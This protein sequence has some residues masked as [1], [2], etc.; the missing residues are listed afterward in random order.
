MKWKE[1]SIRLWTDLSSLGSL[2]FFLFTTL[3]FFSIQQY[4]VV[5]R[6]LGFLII[7]TLLTASLRLIY[8]KDRPRKRTH[9]TLLD[10]IDAGSFPSLHAARIFF[11]ATLFWKSEFVIGI[12]AFAFLV[13]YA[14]IKIEEHTWMD[15][16]TGS[17][18]GVILGLVL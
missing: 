7:A 11:L 10:T 17:V 2:V 1:Y 5:V 8:Y 15:V 12:F 13:A 14:R 4:A 6:C 16:A 9:P 18:I 3:I